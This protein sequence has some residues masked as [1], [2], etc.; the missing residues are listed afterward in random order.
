MSVAMQA[1]TGLS[2]GLLILTLTWKFSRSQYANMRVADLYLHRRKSLNARKEI[3]ELLAIARYELAHNP[4]ITVYSMHSGR[5]IHR[6]YVNPLARLG[7][8]VDE[9][10]HLF[11]H[12][13]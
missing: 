3:D 5:E 12:L 13:G 1:L 9:A 7:L 11:R 6:R 2:S 10:A 4:S 8:I